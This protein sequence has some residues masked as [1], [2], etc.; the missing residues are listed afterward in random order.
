MPTQTSA[1]GR[2]SRGERQ[3]VRFALLLGLR[4][5]REEQF[6]NFFVMGCLFSR[7]RLDFT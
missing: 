2:L 1:V 3:Y 4:F 6:P 5:L 7:V